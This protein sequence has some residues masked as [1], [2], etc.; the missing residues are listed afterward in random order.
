MKP[1]KEITSVDDLLE[2]SG[3]IPP[4]CHQMLNAALVFTDNAQLEFLPAN[5]IYNRAVSV[6]NCPNFRRLEDGCMLLDYFYIVE[7]EDF[8]EIPFNTYL[9]CELCLGQPV[10]ISNL[11]HMPVTEIRDECLYPIVYIDK[12]KTLE[13]EIDFYF[14][15]AIRIVSDQPGQPVDEYPIQHYGSWP[16]IWFKFV[17]GLALRA[18]IERVK[19]SGTQRAKL[20]RQLA[21]RYLTVISDHVPQIER[22]YGAHQMVASSSKTNIEDLRA[23]LLQ[24]SSDAVTKTHMISK[25]AVSAASTITRRF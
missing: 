20:F 12:P 13:H 21:E 23:H 22:A 4:G 2:F 24:L 25:P 9:A 1:V 7:C 14:Q 11:Q 19:L 18:I 17:Y 8:Y 16:F 10:I 15:L 3:T 5:V 6:N